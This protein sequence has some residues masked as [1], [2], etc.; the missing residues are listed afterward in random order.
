[1]VSQNNQAKTVNEHQYGN[2]C[3]Q[4]AKWMRDQIGY[5]FDGGQFVAAGYAV[6]LGD[7]EKD[8]Q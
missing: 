1:M 4:N 8:L 5:L 3:R 2:N 7:T 6:E